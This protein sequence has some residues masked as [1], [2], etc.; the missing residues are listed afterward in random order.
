[1]HKCRCAQ[2]GDGGV[3][4]PALPG[5]S[6]LLRGTSARCHTQSHSQGES[7]VCKFGWCPAAGV[8]V[9]DAQHGS[10]PRRRIPFVCHADLSGAIAES[11]RPLPSPPPSMPRLPPELAPLADVAALAAQPE[12]KGLKA[13]TRMD[14]NK[15]RTAL[16]GV[17]AVP[18]SSGNPLAAQVVR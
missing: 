7:A 5:V 11:C 12:V 18:V 17:D 13:L 9:Q 4:E 2:R 14:A 8:C 3:F 6:K 15:L 1:M 16:L 10:L